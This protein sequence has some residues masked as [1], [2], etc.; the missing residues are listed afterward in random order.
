[1]KLSSLILTVILIFFSLPPSFAKADS[2]LSYYAKITN[3]N[4]FFY[5]QTDEEA[6]LFEIPNSY[7]VLLTDNADDDFYQAKYADLIGFVKKN[8]VTPM[9]GTPSSPYA[10]STKCRV[11]SMSGLPMKESPTF[12]SEDVC[13]LEFLENNVYYYGKKQGQEYFS[14]STNIWYYCKAYSNENAK[15]GYIFSFY[16]DFVSNLRENTEYFE[17]ITQ[18]LVFSNVVQNSAGLSES[19]KAIIILS[20]AIPTLLVV[21]FFLTPK[22]KKKISHSRKKD[23]YELSENDLN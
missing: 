14:N 15:Y 23:Y 11:T 8:Q 10:S 3:D 13:Q 5:S 6:K 21:Y 1:M 19:L 17:E 12:E 16:C 2:K 20:I 4:V 22:K 9:N 18:S 7:F